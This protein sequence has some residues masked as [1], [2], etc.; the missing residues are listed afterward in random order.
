MTIDGSQ[1][2]LTP[3]KREVVTTRDVQVEWP[4]RGPEAGVWFADELAAHRVARN[5]AYRDQ[6]PITA[7]RHNAIAAAIEQA[8]ADL[9]TDEIIAGVRI[10]LV[11]ERE[12]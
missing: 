10:L 2:S 1:A 5:Q 3:R 8:Q 6:M 12:V 4:D 7:R 9:A 11:I